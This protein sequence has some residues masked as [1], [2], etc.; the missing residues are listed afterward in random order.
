MGLHLLIDKVYICC[1]AA[2]SDTTKQA[3]DGMVMLVCPATLGGRL[4][5]SWYLKE[6]S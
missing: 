6:T 5:H 4:R 2:F 1:L 3:L